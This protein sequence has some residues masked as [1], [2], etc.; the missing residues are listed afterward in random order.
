MQNIENLNEEIRQET[1]YLTFLR[2]WEKDLDEAEK[3][4]IENAKKISDLESKLS[5]YEKKLKSRDSLLEKMDKKMNGIK[6]E[7]EEKISDLNSKISTLILELEN[8]V[9]L[10]DKL[11]Q[12]MK[13]S[14]ILNKELTE[15]LEIA[16]EAHQQQVLHLQK[17]NEQ[18]VMER[19]ENRALYNYIRYRFYI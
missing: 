10:V 15:K 7:Y 8:D 17:E 14:Q 19:D 4:K 11:N 6:T 2:R 16:N 13:E 1:N 5:F 3:L 9:L 12:T 18:L